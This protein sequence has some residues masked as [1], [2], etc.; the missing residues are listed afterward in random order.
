MS[1]DEHKIKIEVAATTKKIEARAKKSTK[2]NFSS[3]LFL[4]SFFIH[5][6]SL[7][8]ISPPGYFILFLKN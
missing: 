6:L 1:I 4:A 2:A 8:E 5:I 7:S 3:F